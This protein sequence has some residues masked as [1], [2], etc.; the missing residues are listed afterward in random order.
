MKLIRT[1]NRSHEGKSYWRW[2]IHVPAAAVAR[3]GWKPGE[4]L[5]LRIEGNVL[6]ISS[7]LRSETQEVKDKS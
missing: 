2:K 5:D 6:K 1:V 3:L 7:C 4:E